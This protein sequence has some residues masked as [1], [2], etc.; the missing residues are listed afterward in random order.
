MKI[1][2]KWCIFADI[3]LSSIACKGKEFCLAKCEKKKEE[4]WQQANRDD[5]NDA[6]QSSVKGTAN[7]I[8]RNYLTIILTVYLFAGDVMHL[9]FRTLPVMQKAG[10]KTGLNTCGY[11]YEYN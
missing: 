4:F 6:K 11:P 10:W 8:R 2:R 3:I 9:E 5:A 7:I 1:N